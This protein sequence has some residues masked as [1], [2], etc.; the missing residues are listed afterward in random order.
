MDIYRGGIVDTGQRILKMEL[1]G[2]E[3]NLG[4]SWKYEDM[5]RTGVTDA[6]DRTRASRQSAKDFKLSVW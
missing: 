3:Q 4:G 2:K 6:R 1:P 5:Q